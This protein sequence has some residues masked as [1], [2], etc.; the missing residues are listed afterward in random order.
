MSICKSFVKIV[1]LEEH[2]VLIRRGYDNEDESNY[3]S[4]T[5]LA[6]DE[7]EMTQTMRFKSDISDERYDEIWNSID[8]E[9]AEI[10]LGEM[11]KN[12]FWDM[13]GDE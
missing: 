4:L 3:I 7:C 11:Q 2:Q 6:P 9:N 13:S 8:R 12:P 1:E 10:F 5:I